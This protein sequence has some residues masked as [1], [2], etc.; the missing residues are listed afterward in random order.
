MANKSASFHRNK[1]V[2]STKMKDSMIV[3]EVVLLV[4]FVFQCKNTLQLIQVLVGVIE[5]LAKK[6]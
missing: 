5:L 6:V 1:L 4:G 3:K 2:R